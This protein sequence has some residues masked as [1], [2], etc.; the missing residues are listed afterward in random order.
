MMVVVVRG[1]AR[2]P[3]RRVKPSQPSQD[4][5]HQQDW[6]TSSKGYERPARWIEKQSEMPRRH[7]GAAWSKDQ[8]G[9]GPAHQGEKVVYDAVIA[10]RDKDAQMDGH[11]GYCREWAS[12]T[13]Q[14]L[15]GIAN[16]ASPEHIRRQSAQG[17]PNIILK[18][19]SA[20][21]GRM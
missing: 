4:P 6:L 10:L 17:S 7:N 12:K 11:E 8:G 13:L 19:K 14:R 1:R 15:E 18:R 3:A 21:S 2:T 9:L 5:M 16:A 20:V